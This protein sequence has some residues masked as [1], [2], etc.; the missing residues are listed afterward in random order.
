M[1]LS[2]ISPIS[3]MSPIPFPTNSINIRCNKKKRVIIDKIYKQQNTK[4][5]V[6]T[7]NNGI[8]SVDIVR[9]YKTGFD[10]IYTRKK[11]HFV[12]DRYNLINADI[13]YYSLSKIYECNVMMDPFALSFNDPYTAEITIKYNDIWGESEW[14]YIPKKEQKPCADNGVFCC[15]GQV[16]YEKEEFEQVKETKP[17]KT[18]RKKLRCILVCIC[19]YMY[20]MYCMYKIFVIC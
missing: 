6:I 18:T 11:K 19:V 5:K 10:K 1:Q 8:F 13:E 9:H 16:F 3:P 15:C 7:V 14:W 20:C 17:T 4:R 2:P 12:T